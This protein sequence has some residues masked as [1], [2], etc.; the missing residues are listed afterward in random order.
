VVTVKTAGDLTRLAEL[1]AEALGPTLG[2][3]L[4]GTFLRH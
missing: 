4:D 1:D 3:T 2:L